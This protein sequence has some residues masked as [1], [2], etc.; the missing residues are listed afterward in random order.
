MHITCQI[1]SHTLQ[2]HQF[3]LL[4]IFLFFFYVFSRNKM[5]IRRKQ[6]MSCE[7]CKKNVWVWSSIRRS[8]DI[9]SI[10][11]VDR[12]SSYNRD[13]VS[14]GGQKLEWSPL[15]QSGKYIWSIHIWFSRLR[16]HDGCSCR[17]EPDYD[18]HS[19]VKRCSQGRY[20]IH[21]THGWY[22]LVNI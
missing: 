4:P 2:S 6:R 14:T 3:F 21:N 13:V 20:T 17:K 5:L 9:S 7:G 15:W 18:T 22:L 8:W 10:T 19:W 11:G 12:Y 1:W 16:V